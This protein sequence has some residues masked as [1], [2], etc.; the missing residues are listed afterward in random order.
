MTLGLAGEASRPE[1][2]GIFGP[3]RPTP[4]DLTLRKVVR[5]QYDA[6]TQQLTIHDQVEIRRG[7]SQRYFE[8]AF[9]I[10]LFTPDEIV[11]LLT[12]AGFVGVGMFGDFDLKPW[13]QDAPRWIVV[14]ERP[15]T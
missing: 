4:P 1:Q 12:Q 15:L 8:Y 7:D 3:F 14:A 10:R 6:A 2:T 5:N 11:R 9:A 13:H